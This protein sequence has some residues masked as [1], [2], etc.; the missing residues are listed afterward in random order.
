MISNAPATHIRGLCT[1][2]TNVHSW[3]AS[4]VDV[5]A[6]GMEPIVARFTMNV[7]MYAV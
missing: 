7:S 2:S 3:K 1:E 5:N 4:A 6:F